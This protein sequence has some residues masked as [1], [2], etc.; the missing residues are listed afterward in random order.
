MVTNA[1]FIFAAHGNVIS[2][3]VTALT[4]H[5]TSL[6]N[7]VCLLCAVTPGK[8][9]SNFESLI[10][11]M[12]R[13]LSRGNWCTGATRWPRRELQPRCNWNE[14]A[15]PGGERLTAARRP[16]VFNPCFSLPIPYVSLT[17]CLAKAGRRCELQTLHQATPVGKPIQGA[18]VGVLSWGL[19]VVLFRAAEA[20]LAVPGCPFW[21]SWGGVFSGFPF[22]FF[23]FFCF[24][25][26]NCQ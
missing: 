12:H 8:N 20:E 16:L 6:L 9:G 21:G 10:R 5:W 3:S 14:I 24:F 19:E 22:F 13:W 1:F 4:R 18:L 15:D 23:G 17:G 11:K 2:V 26:C 7:P 25:F